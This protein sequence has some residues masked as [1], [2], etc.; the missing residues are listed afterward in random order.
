MRWMT[1]MTITD[2]INIKG[3]NNA[4]EPR[5]HWS[6][7][8]LENKVNDSIISAVRHLILPKLKVF[9]DRSAVIAHDMKLN[10]DSI[11]AEWTDGIEI[12]GLRALHR[13]YTLQYILDRREAAINKQNFNGD[14]L[15]TKAAEIR[16][17][18]QEIVNR[19]QQHYRYPISSI[20]AKRWDHT[21]YHFGYLYLA[22][23]LHFWLREEEQARRNNYSPFFMNVWNIWRIAGIIK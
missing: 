15:L 23:D 14:S 17:K 5:P 22:S 8:L 20:A 1:A 12:T 10:T 6:Y 3:L 19:R 13:Y 11:S 21:A 2:E 18:A 16:A 9:A 7:K 4:Y